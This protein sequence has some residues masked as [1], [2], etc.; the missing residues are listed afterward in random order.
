MSENRTYRVAVTGSNGQLGKELA[1]IAGDHPGF[2]F[3]FLSREDFPLNEPEKMESWLNRNPVDIFIHSAAYTAV[4]KAESE[5]EKAYLINATASGLIASRL[6]PIRAKLIYISTDYVFDGTSSIPLTEDSPTNPINWYGATKLEG[7]RLVLQNNP[8]SQ[9]IRTSWVYSAYGNNFVKTMMRLMNE[10]P[11]VKVV[12]DQRGSPTYAADLAEAILQILES[13]HFTP[14]I[15]HYSNEGEI[16]WYDFAVE[17]KR[18]TGS[19]CEV[20]PIPS[21][22]FPTAAKRPDYSLLDKSKIKRV[23]GLAIPDWKT[24]LAFC[25]QQIKQGV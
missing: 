4:D 16:S 21:A 2:R 10:K 3:I 13:E 6:S 5:N 19:S 15:Y 9:V 17:I 20:L 1:S 22:G 25:I 18:L 8:E 14:G 12:Q 23:Y 24:S 7:E 11:S